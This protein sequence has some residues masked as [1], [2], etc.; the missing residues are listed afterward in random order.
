[1]ISPKPL[2]QYLLVTLEI[3]LESAIVRLE[4]EYNSIGL[5]RVTL[6]VLDAFRQ[7]GAVEILVL[8]S[9]DLIFPDTRNI[10]ESQ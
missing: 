6:L 2:R 8:L 7:D 4:K 1:L 3:Y 9:V 10:H 5:T